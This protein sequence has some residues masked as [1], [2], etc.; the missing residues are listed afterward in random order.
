MEFNGNFEVKA[1][2][3]SV[4]SFISDIDK[5]ISVIPDVQSA[6]RVNDSSSRLV[7]KAGQSVIKG[8]FN[9]FLEIRN[10][11][12]DRSV[13]ISAK[14]SGTSGSIDLRAIYNFS[15][16]PSGSTIVQ[17]NVVLSIGGMVATMGSRIINSTADRYISVLTDSFRKAFEK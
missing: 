15:D 14:G 2:R 11:V 16:S 7:V 8:K 4:F 17:W 10:K 3:H 1:E 13:E 6:E 5:I 9:L 12:E